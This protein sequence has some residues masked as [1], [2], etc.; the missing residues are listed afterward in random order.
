MKFVLEP[1]LTVLDEGLI[2]PF[3]PA[4]AFTVHL[5]GLAASATVEVI[6]TSNIKEIIRIIREAYSPNLR[7]FSSKCVLK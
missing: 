4:V 5:V 1:E 2:V 3:G 7:Y 6:R